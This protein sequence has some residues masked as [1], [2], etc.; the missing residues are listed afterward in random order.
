MA[1]LTN[2]EIGT[3]SS[4]TNITA[5]LS[6]DSL[7][8]TATPLGYPVRIA[9]AAGTVRQQGGA[10]CAWIFPGLLQ[11]QWVSLRALIPGASATIYIRTLDEDNYTYVYK[12][13]VAVWPEPGDIGR[14]SSPKFV[15]DSLTIRFQNLVTFTP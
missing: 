9:T 1:Y 4:T 15:C 12:T 3:T 11:A 13:G 14:K 5:V 8:P 10:Q 6:N 2:L 7:Y